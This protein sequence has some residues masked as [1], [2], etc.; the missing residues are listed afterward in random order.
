[1]SDFY[2][3][4]DRM[5]FIRRWSLMRSVRDENILEH[6]G[7]VAMFTHALCAIQNE[8]Y[9]GHV[10]VEKAVLYAL[11]H[12]VSEVVTG[13][14]PTPIK[15]S[16][17]TI[18]QSFHT[19]EDQAVERIFSTLPTNLQQGY[20]PMLKPDV[21]SEEYALMKCADKLSAYVKCLEEIRSGN[22]E[23]VMAEKTIRKELEKRS[24]TIPALS[25]FMK[26]F[27]DGFS[28]SLDELNY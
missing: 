9:S 2:A 17:G 7:Q 28:R 10:N 3:L 23:F 15:Y 25:Y 8:V 11:Y 16:N 26:E 14:L 12:E 20:S 13:D 4:L 19:L 21:S 22:S 27:I 6:S 1:M 24:Q 5:K 18:E